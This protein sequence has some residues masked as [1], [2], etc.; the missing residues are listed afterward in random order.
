MIVVDE[1]R[2][3]HTTGD[4]TMAL[5]P[6]ELAENRDNAKDKEENRLNTWVAIT[7]ALLATFMAICEVKDD[8]VVQGMMQAQA[9]KID[10]WAW[11]QARNIRQ[12]VLHTAAVG[13]HAQAKAASSDEV[14]KLYLA[15]ADRHEALAAKQEAKMAELEKTARGDDATYDA[16][17][18]HDDQFD[19]SKASLSIAIALLAMT[20][21]TKKRWLFWVAMVPAALGIIMG[22]AGLLGLGLHPDF[23]IKPLT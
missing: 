4:E 3:T 7:V 18:R 2:S 8:N 9:D 22:L 11:Y 13:F 16:L 10:N 21:L 14:R 1:G 15:E 19:L 23:L 12:E 17:N 5:D 6:L 20:A